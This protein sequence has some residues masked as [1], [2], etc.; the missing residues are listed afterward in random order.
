MTDGKPVIVPNELSAAINAKLDAA[1][2]E[3]PEEDRASAERDREFLYGQLL[4]AY[5]KCGFIPNFTLTK[6]G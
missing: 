5:D 2:A 6:L 1:I 3:L 4:D